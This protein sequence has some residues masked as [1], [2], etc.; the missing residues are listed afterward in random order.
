MTDDI[1]KKRGGISPDRLKLHAEMEP[2]KTIGEDGKP[3]WDVNTAKEKSEYVREFYDQFIKTYCQEDWWPSTCSF[4]FLSL[5]YHL[6]EQIQKGYLRMLDSENRIVDYARIKDELG[7]IE[8]FNQV[9]DEIRDLIE[10][11][12]DFKN[13]SRRLQMRYHLYPH[14]KERHPENWITIKEVWDWIAENYK[15][16]S[17]R[18]LEALRNCESLRPWSEDEKRLCKEAQAKNRAQEKIRRAAISA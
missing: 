4:R 12:E 3:H 18:E 5:L 7:N 10:K 15:R 1:M 11:G 16:L 14:K 17:P 2:F 9:C 6:D 13:H 8:N